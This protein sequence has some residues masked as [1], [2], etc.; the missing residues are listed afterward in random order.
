M[1]VDAKSTI[2]SEVQGG[3]GTWQLLCFWHLG[4]QTV[5][6]HFINLV[7]WGPKAS[8]PTKQNLCVRNTTHMS[9]I[10]HVMNH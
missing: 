7:A 8:A 6:C 4:I 3:T 1:S 10:I 2:E 9:I 5:Y